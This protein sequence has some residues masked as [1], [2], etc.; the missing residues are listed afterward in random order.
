MKAAI[1]V[2]GMRRKLRF[3]SLIHTLLECEVGRFVSF[4]TQSTPQSA[5]EFVKRLGLNPKIFGSL[6]MTSFLEILR[7]IVGS[8]KLER[9]PTLFILKMHHSQREWHSKEDV[10]LTP[11]WIRINETYQL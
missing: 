5:T 8:R 11:S 4:E 7:T 10:S 1:L 2:T 3:A 6:G 9:R